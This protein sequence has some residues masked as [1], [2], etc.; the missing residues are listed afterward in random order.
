VHLGAEEA[1]QAFWRSCHSTCRR[2]CTGRYG[3]AHVAPSSG[4]S[5]ESRNRRSSGKRSGRR[6][7]PG[8]SLCNKRRLS[9]SLTCKQ[10]RGG[11]LVRGRSWSSD[12]DSP[13]GRKAWRTGSPVYLDDRCLRSLQY[14]RHLCDS[15]HLL[16]LPLHLVRL[17]PHLVDSPG[18]VAGG[19]RVVIISPQGKSDCWS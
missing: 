6:V 19:S 12:S 14:Q 11:G 9:H 1:A 15:P 3:R 8:Q 17:P 7:R 5:G 10:Y 18:K 4:G 13:Y 16:R 2:A